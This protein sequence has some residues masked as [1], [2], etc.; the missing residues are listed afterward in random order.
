MESIADGF[1]Y[2]I[3]PFVEQLVAITLK[4]LLLL[5]WLSGRQAA[6]QMGIK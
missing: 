2:V 1:A 3:N 5:L 4:L 6:L